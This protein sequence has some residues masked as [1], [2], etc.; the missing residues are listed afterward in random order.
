M[1]SRQQ[2]PFLGLAAEREQRRVSTSTSKCGLLDKD[3]IAFGQSSLS[4]F[5][6]YNS[7]ALQPQDLDSMLINDDEQDSY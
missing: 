7:K 3:S 2:A 1:P 5:S 6:V 4:V